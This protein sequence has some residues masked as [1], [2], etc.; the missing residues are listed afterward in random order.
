[1]WCLLSC[2][3]LECFRRQCAKHR[4][5]LSVPAASGNTVSASALGALIMFLTIHGPASDGRVEAARL[6]KKML[7]LGVSRF[8]P[9]P[10]A[11]LAEATHVKRGITNGKKCA[12]CVAPSRIK[13]ETEQTCF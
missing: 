6:P 5:R 10:E 2:T 7:A 13:S 8:H 3:A 4:S 11:A 9:D 1:M 12:Q